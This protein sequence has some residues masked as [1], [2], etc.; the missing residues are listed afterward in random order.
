MT[1]TFETEEE[2]IEYKKKVHTLCCKKW[3]ETHKEEMRAYHKARY[4]PREKKPTKKELRL[5]EKLKNDELK[6][7]AVLN[8]YEKHIDEKAKKKSFIKIE[9]K[10]L[11]KNLI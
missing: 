9:K 2:R 1:L 7:L 3:N 11:E 4:I 6:K 5:Q 10:I 8:D